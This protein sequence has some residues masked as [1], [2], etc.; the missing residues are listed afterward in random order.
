MDA[1]IVITAI[2]CGLIGC[3]CSQ[4]G[5]FRQQQPFKASRASTVRVEANK[6]VQKKAKVR[7]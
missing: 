2:Q 6:R 7:Q 4:R 5:A 1:R 3:L